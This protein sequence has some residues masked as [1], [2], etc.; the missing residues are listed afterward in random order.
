MSGRVPDIL[1]AEYPAIQ[2]AG[3]DNQPATGNKNGWISPVNPTHK[4][5]IMRELT[6]ANILSKQMY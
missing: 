1:E 6:L 3:L 4:K 5:Q 2:D